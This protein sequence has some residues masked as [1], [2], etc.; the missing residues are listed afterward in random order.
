M[1]A[2]STAN[3]YINGVSADATMKQLRAESAKLRNEIASLSPT[4]QEFINKTAQF[5]QVQKRLEDVNGELR[6]TKGLFGQMHAEIGK[7]GTMALAYLGFDA[8]TG[9]VGNMIRKNAELS[10]S[11]AD[12]QKTTGLTEEEVK[13][14]N[15][16]LSNYDTRTARNELLA[17]A[18]DAG[19]LGITGKRDIEEF[20][21]AADKINVALGEDLGQDAIKQIGKLVNVFQLKE[22]FGLEQS[23]IKVA[24]AINDLGMSSEAN[25]GFLVNFL[26][27]M[28]GI[29]PLAN[30]SID[31]TLALGATLDALGQTA[32]VSSTALSQLF[33]KMAKDAETYARI[34]GVS[35]DE[36]KKKMNENALEAFLMVLEAAGNTEGGIIK[37]TETLGDLGIEGGRATGVFGALAKNTDMLKKQMDIANA[38]FEKG[39][40][41]IDEFNTKNENLAAKLEKLQKWFGGLF[42]NN[43]F[44]E[45]M[46]QFVDYAT[47]LI[48]VPLSEK[49]EQ[50]RMELRKLELQLLNTNLPQ[51]DRVKL[52]KQLQDQYP[53]YFGNLNAETASNQQVMQSLR[54]LNDEMI[55]KIIL[56]KE[57]EN[58]QRNN[59]KIAEKRLNFLNREDKLRS[60]IIATA[61][62]N[63]IQ[64]K[65]GLND[66]QQALYVLGKVESTGSPALD[67]V[68]TRQQLANAYG[69]YA[70][71]LQA[72]NEQEERGNILLGARDEL[73]KRLG[74]NEQ[75]QQV[76]RTITAEPVASGDEP[77]VPGITSAKTQDEAYKKALEKL[78][79]YFATEKAIIKTNMAA[80]LENRATYEAE[81][82]A[83]ET[84]Q[85]NMRKDLLQ[86]FK[87]DTG[88]I[89]LQIADNR[90]K[91]AEEEVKRE[92][93]AK[94]L[95]FEA[96]KTALIEEENLINENFANGIINQEQHELQLQELKIGSLEI[97]RIAHEA[98][99]DSTIETEKK[100]AAEKAK[101]EK[102]KQKYQLETVDQAKRLAQ[103]VAI[104]ER[105]STLARQE[106]FTD[107]LFAARGFFKENTTL[108]KM[109]LIATKAAAIAEIVIRAQLEKAAASAASAFD[110]TGILGMVRRQM[111]NARMATS[112]AIV[113]A[114]TVQEV[115]GF[116]SG[117]YT[118]P[119]S[120]VA[121]KSGKKVAGVVHENEYVVP[122]WMLRK[123]EYANVVA[124]L[125]SQRSGESYDGFADGGDTRRD[126]RRQRRRERNFSEDGTKINQKNDWR[127]SIEM[128][129]NSRDYHAEMLSVTREQNTI[130]KEM[131]IELQQGLV[132]GDDKLYEMKERTTKLQQYE[133]NAQIK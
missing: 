48:A 132:V 39:N 130:L 55:N 76:F 119:G 68:S 34:A 87:M 35:T 64:L 117:G 60:Q 37:L 49:M 79:E 52:I 31:Q 7:F 94:A 28:G 105:Q 95:A 29:A 123:P 118:G 50:E 58:I 128:N 81:L 54:A 53:N 42:V 129:E 113:T 17:L 67:M 116:A 61:E 12:V 43:A 16:E 56:Q 25:E 6:Q 98:Y 19:K 107:L 77:A 44:L 93:E 70:K 125:E 24:S 86:K 63:N 133:S 103:E 8:I 22:E 99:G 96:I 33:V 104:A 69:N 91:L 78:N 38:G 27:R 65:N 75:D 32:E 88:D 97:M 14:L 13:K 90:I 47:R 62:K 20:V 83:V 121:D 82:L 73:M 115:A 2:K 110:P 21:K 9:K 80:D 26:N 74:I 10:D 51:G 71:A 3:I 126:R 114:Q 59:E 127:A 92:A 18:R 36:F 5:K 11:F 106:N 45:G 23:M 15:K 72:M 122:E 85:L 109:A 100:I 30:I 131:L 46:K 57:D 41:V 111:I 1:Q 112:I 4:S 40:S 84:R 102:L 124:W 101:Y 89:E 108:A 120:G 66:V